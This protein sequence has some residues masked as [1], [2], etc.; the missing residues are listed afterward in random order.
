MAELPSF[1]PMSRPLARTWQVYGSGFVN[2]ATNELGVAPDE[3]DPRHQAYLDAV[4]FAVAGWDTIPWHGRPDHENEIWMPYL[5]DFL[6]TR[7]KIMTV[8]DQK[9]RS[10][11]TKASAAYSPI[12]TPDTIRLLELMPAS[13]GSS[14][15]G[16][17]HE[18]NLEFTW[19]EMDVSTPLTPHRRNN[20]QTN[21]AISLAH[22]KPV[23]YTALSYVW[24]SPKLDRTLTI[25]GV[26]KKITSAL[27]DILTHLRHE[28]R[29]VLLWV[30]QICIDQD[31]ASD[32]EA[33]I[34]LMGKIYS[35]AW[36]T[37]I[38]LEMES[39]KGGFK[40]LEGMYEVLRYRRDSRLL[41]HEIEDILYP[42]AG[43]DRQALISLKKLLRQPWFQRTWVI[44]EACLSLKPYVMTGKTAMP[45]SDF[46]AWCNTI[47]DVMSIDRDPDLGSSQQSS[48]G[49]LPLDS[50]QS[51]AQ[52]Y[53][54]CVGY[55]K[56]MPNQLI[57]MLMKTRYAQVT[58]P[59]DKVYGIL[60]L[61]KSRIKPDYSKSLLSLYHDVAVEVVQ[62]RTSSDDC[63]QLLCCIDHEPTVGL[64][65]W[66]VDWSR[67]R[68]T[69]SLG[70]GALL[71][72][73]FDTGGRAVP[74]IRW[75]AHVNL[76]AD[77]KTL[78]LSGKLFGKVQRLSNVF[79]SAKLS[80]ES[81]PMQNTSLFEAV[82]FATSSYSGEEPHINLF[83]TLCATL[84]AGRDG[85]DPVRSPPSFLEIFSLLCDQT[86][87][88]QPS[89]PGQTYTPR[90]QKGHFTTANLKS[91][92]AGRE[93]QSLK[94][95]YRAAMRNRRLCWSGNGYLGLVPRHTR[96]GDMLC[97]FRNCVVPFVVRECSGG[98]YEVGGEC[99]VHDV[100]QGELVDDERVPAEMI[101]LR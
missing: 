61:C 1:D 38:W 7:S 22:G 54:I 59:L 73:Y 32:K 8:D 12:E 90:Q 28:D 14:L 65:S 57:T 81:C 49:K 13:S 19:P 80:A 30:D 70:V 45:W 83:T 3:H 47:A 27:Y 21:F 75:H 4:P 53:D 79:T 20:R 62:G 56:Y 50:L 100:M 82:T 25:N 6:T 97:V 16:T 95:A 11:Q 101:S 48:V 98:Q 10:V 44:Q 17:L 46:S 24:G 63:Y 66:A 42:P 92:T 85:Y 68:E 86:T 29:S 69:T 76:S 71:K 41:P 72:G 84:V 33:Q 15:Q 23:C 52:L 99:Y 39:D 78:H 87:G 88:C 74:S 55:D 96:V 77:N 34:Q 9:G 5:E 37:V 91:R 2:T 40:T 67:P 64:P 31:N 26:D 18:V 36:N 58:N 93:F 43:E 89:I 51:A 94:R 35:R 60:G